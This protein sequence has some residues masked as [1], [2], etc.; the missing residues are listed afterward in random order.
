MT[1]T[2]LFSPARLHVYS[3]ALVIGAA[4]LPALLL[5]R[6]VWLIDPAGIPLPSDFLSFWSAGYLA[7]QGKAA[8]AYDFAAHGAIEVQAVG[9]SFKGYF[10]WFYPPTFLIPMTALASLPYVAAFAVWTVLTLGAYLVAARAIVR[11]RITIALAFAA[12]PSILNLIAGQTGYLTAALLGGGLV[13][14]NSHP[15]V[16]GVL[17]G[18]M[19]WKPQFGLLIPV[20]LLITGRWRTIASA[21]ATAAILAAV[22][23]AIFGSATWDAFLHSA[24][25]AG[26]VLLEKGA[27][28][29]NKLQSVYALV[30]WLGGGATVAW[31][32]H[33]AVAALI[34]WLVAR[35]WLRRAPYELQAAALSAGALMVTP[36]L[37]FYDLTVMTVPVAFL[38]RYGL[39]HGFV[40][41]QRILLACLFV[42]TI[43]APWLGV[44][45]LG[46]VALAVLMG[47]ILSSEAAAGSSVAGSDLGSLGTGFSSGRRGH[48]GT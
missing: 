37:L 23:L 8:L 25:T 14:L 9:P 4:L 32:A 44:T 19:T 20:V 16:A 24:P 29:W 12:P 11:S 48:E 30:R 10:S 41:H 43:P 33:G 34:C 28:G 45:P 39:A 21:A 42:L 46:A 22:A 35:V 26:N 5:F 40:R 3:L 6:G 18:L 27:T 36:F 17:F 38:V 13:L 31:I 15:V 1:E 7:L 47:T 2:A